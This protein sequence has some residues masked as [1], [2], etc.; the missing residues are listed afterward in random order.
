MLNVLTIFQFFKFC[1]IFHVD[2]A[3]S[4]S[5]CVAIIE[6]YS[7]TKKIGG[8]LSKFANDLSKRLN[9]KNSLKYHDMDLHML[10]G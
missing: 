7:D 1:H 8:M 5:L 3:P 9:A 4:A 6:Q 2:Q 10:V